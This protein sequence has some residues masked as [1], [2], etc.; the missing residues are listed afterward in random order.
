MNYIYNAVSL[1]RSHIIG[2][3]PM[4]P[5]QDSASKSPQHTIANIPQS[6]C[7]DDI[8]LNTK[9]RRR[10]IHASQHAR[11]TKNAPGQPRL[12]I[13]TIRQKTSR[14]HNNNIPIRDIPNTSSPPQ[15]QKPPAHSPSTDPRPT[16]PNLAPPR[17]SHRFQPTDPPVRRS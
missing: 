13:H 9:P 12:S 16:A 6:E 14:D 8:Q 2:D 5:T 11:T 3:F 4:S 17:M 7:F 15:K 10:C 1:R